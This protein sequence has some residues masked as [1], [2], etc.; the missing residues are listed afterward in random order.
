MSHK[1]TLSALVIVASVAG[2]AE[3]QNEINTV[4]NFMEQGCNVL[5]ADH[6]NSQVRITELTGRYYRDVV[7]SGYGNAE[8]RN[9]VST[10][11]SMTKAIAIKGCET[12]PE[13]VPT[14]ITGG[15]SSYWN[16]Y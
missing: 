3:T 5:R 7:N 8:V 1:F 15:T 16:S 12:P 2:C 13:F 14:H 6:Y 4:Q 10:L 11:N 9:Q